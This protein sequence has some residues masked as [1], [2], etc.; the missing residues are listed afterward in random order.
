MTTPANRV[1]SPFLERNFAPI[2]D[3][4]EAENLPVL[5][6]LPP[7][8][9]G[10]FVRNGPNPQFHPI[11]GYH[12]FGGDGML[13]GVSLRDGKAAYR[14]RWV[15]TEAW[16]RER[17]AGRALWPSDMRGPDLEN[18]EGPMRGNTAN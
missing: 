7:E 13:H 15:R 17:A 14:N 4:I 10:V 9:D 3:E 16:S 5:G 8:L 11:R 12:W 6:E 2:R 1:E 18:P